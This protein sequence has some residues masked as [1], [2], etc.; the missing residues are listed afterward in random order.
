MGKIIQEE[1]QRERREMKKLKMSEDK[2]LMGCYYVKSFQEAV[3]VHQLGTHDVLKRKCSFIPMKYF[4]VS[5][6][7]SAPQPISVPFRLSWQRGK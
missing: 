6:K 3:E 2:R 7:Y 1:Q 4:A 5:S